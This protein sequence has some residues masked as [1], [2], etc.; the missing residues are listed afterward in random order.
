VVI[1]A[2]LATANPATD[3]A[4]EDKIPELFKIASFIAS[5]LK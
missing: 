3:L 2:P 5:R 1:A 4:E